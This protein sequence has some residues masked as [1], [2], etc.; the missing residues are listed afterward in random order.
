MTEVLIIDDDDAVRAAFSRILRHA[1]FQVTPVENGVAALHQVRQREFDVVVCDYRMPELGGQGFYEQVEEYFPLIA[2]RV[3]F[4][5]A[6]AEDPKIQ[7]FLAQT[8]QPVLGK[9]VENEKL[10]DAVNQIVARNLRR[11]SS[12]GYGA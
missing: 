11:P 6:F 3:V 10:I 1:G 8:G 9:P 12:P 4:V 7:T 2:G 5:T